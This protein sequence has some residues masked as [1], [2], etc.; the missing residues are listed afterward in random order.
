MIYEARV[1]DNSEFY[2]TGKIWVRIKEKTFIKAN[3]A[4]L[5]KKP[6]LIEDF[7]S[8]ETDD[9]GNETL[10][11]QDF[12]CYLYSPMGGGF[13]FGIFNL[14]QVNS[15]GIVAEVG[16]TYVPNKKVYVWLGTVFKPTALKTLTIPNPTLTD[17]NGIVQGESQMGDLDGNAIVIKTRSTNLEDPTDVADNADE[18]DFE[19]RPVENLIVLD[20]NKIVVSHNII[21][22]DNNIL[23]NEQITLNNDEGLT[24][25]MLKQKSASNTTNVINTMAK[26]DENGYLKYQQ[27]GKDENNIDFSTDGESIK[28]MVYD[29]KGKYSSSIEQ[30]NDSINVVAGNSQIDLENT[31]LTI[32]TSSEVVLD[33]KRVS[34]GSQGTNYPVALITS[35][36]STVTIDNV[37]LLASTKAFG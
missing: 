10:V 2:T 11:H 13:D 34:L 29:S 4:D 19:Q 37:T 15:T 27:F 20:K 24:Y 31:T 16:E 32:K 28:S 30:S 3:Y 6:E 18:L 9:S 21:D 12:P 8:K 7:V 36:A 1:I 17:S 5:S 22:D 23:G 35:G 25:Q 14:P 33:A 26:I